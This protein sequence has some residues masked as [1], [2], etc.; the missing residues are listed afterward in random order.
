MVLEYAAGGE[1]FDLIARK[2]KVR[3][4]YLNFT[5]SI[6][7]FLKMMQGKFFNK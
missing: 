4:T 5:L 1:L 7:S 6:N 3:I 2:E